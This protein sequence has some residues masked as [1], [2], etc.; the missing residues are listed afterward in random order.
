MPNLAYCGLRVAVK[1]LI[2]RIANGFSVASIAAAIAAVSGCVPYPVIKQLQPATEVRVTDNAGHPLPGAQVTLIAEFDP[3]R[4]E[5]HRDT[6]PTD[7]EGRV[8]FDSRHELRM[9]AM[10]L[11]GW[12]EFFWNLCITQSGYV[13]AE[14]VFSAGSDW[15]P[16][17]D[18]ALQPGV[19][20]PCR[21]TGRNPG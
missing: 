14:T 2:R 15:Q 6:L 10:M 19:S 17:F 16:R 4:Q 1:L 13:T 20:T 8:H 11:H 18:F 9:E 12:T 21:T 5:H 7:A 3:Y